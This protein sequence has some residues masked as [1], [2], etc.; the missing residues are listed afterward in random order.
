EVALSEAEH[1]KLANKRSKKDF[2]MY[3]ASGSGAGVRPEVPY[4]PKYASKSDEE[5]STFSQDVDDAD[6][7]TDV[8]DDSEETKFVNDGDDLT[9]PNLSTYKADYKEEEEKEEE[10]KMMIKC[11]LIK[12][13]TYHQTI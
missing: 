2:H 7:E 11:L 13:C 4:V 5:S 9:H 6:E 1:V 12:E 3:H 8:N 10:K